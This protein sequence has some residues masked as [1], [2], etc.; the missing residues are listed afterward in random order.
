MVGYSRIVDWIVGS[1]RCCQFKV[2]A[3]TP[4]L[5]YLTEVTDTVIANVKNRQI[6]LCSRES[7]MLKILHELVSS[8]LLVVTAEVL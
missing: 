2:V 4:E 1:V 7:V 3:G 8:L 5:L 6:V